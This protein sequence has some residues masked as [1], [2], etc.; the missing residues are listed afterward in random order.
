M[1]CDEDQ[2]LRAPGGVWA[3]NC[4]RCRGRPLG[5]CRC[6]CSR[7]RTQTGDGFASPCGRARWVQAQSVCVTTAAW[8]AALLMAMVMVTVVAVRRCGHW[9]WPL[10]AQLS[11]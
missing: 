11:P 5:R 10:H 6:R 3:G 7:H 4:T 1:C 9:D 8:E 2:M